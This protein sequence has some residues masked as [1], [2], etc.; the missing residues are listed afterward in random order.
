[1]LLNPEERLAYWGYKHMNVACRDINEDDE[2]DMTG[3]ERILYGVGFLA[4][5]GLTGIRAFDDDSC[6]DDEVA[7]EEGE[8]GAGYASY[9]DSAESELAEYVRGNNDNDKAHET[10]TY[11]IE[12]EAEE[13]VLDE[14]HEEESEIEEAAESEEPQ[15]DAES[16]EPSPVLV[17]EYM[18]LDNFAM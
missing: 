13:I 2:P 1:M 5:T 10:K 14:T 17:L 6:P 3:L 7:D 12:H 15:F 8:S 11:P 16:I 18:I 9:S 4:V